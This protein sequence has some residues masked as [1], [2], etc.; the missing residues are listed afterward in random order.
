[1]V[2]FCWLRHNDNGNRH[3]DR[4]G[5]VKVLNLYAGIGGNRKLWEDVEVTAVEINADIAKVYQGFFPNDKVIVGDAHQY[6]LDR[7]QEFDFIWSS[8]PCPTHSRINY[9]NGG[10]W[11]VK[12]PDMKLYQEIILLQEWFNGKYVV[13]NVISYYVPLVKPQESGRHYFWANFNIPKKDYGVQIGTLMHGTRKITLR[14]A[15]IPELMSLH[16]FDL[17]KINIP[18][19]RQVLRNCVFPE[20]GQLI[21]ECA[22]GIIKKEDISQT[23]LFGKHYEKKTTR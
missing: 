20:L 10:R 22:R 17:S 6:L 19:K 7:Y 5:A 2:S 1:M 3:I 16:G 8:P 21:L 4:G 14:E 15:Q 9:S 12:Y 13:E 11:A 18:N 23:S